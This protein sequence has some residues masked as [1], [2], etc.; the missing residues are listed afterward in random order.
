MMATLADVL[1]RIMLEA[2]LI[3]DVMKHFDADC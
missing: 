2:Q 3:T 1:H